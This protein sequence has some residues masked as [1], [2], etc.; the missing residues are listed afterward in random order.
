MA[1]K[2]I[3]ALK[4]YLSEPCCAV[5]F[6]DNLEVINK[7][8]TPKVNWIKGVPKDRWYADPF[9]LAVTNSTVELLVERY[10]YEDGKGV[11]SH[12]LI[13]RKNNHLIRESV[14]L[15][16]TTHLSF[17]FIIEENDVI[18]VMPE[19]YQSGKLSV[20]EYD[21]Y[22][23][24]LINQHILIN[25]PL[26]DAV[27]K[28]IDGYYYIFATK[29]DDNFYEAAKTLYV[30][31]STSLKGRYILIQTISHEKAEVRGAG[32]IIELG[33]NFIRPSQDCNDGY[34]RGV[35]F[36]KLNL[37][38]G[39][40]EIAEYDRLFPSDRRYSLGLHTYN[41]TSDIVVVDGIG[42]RRSWLSKI[43]S[44][45]YKNINKIR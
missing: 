31:R 43:A 16:L 39:I 4:L 23:N 20:Y 21:R 18:Y 13:N 15:E 41:R 9:I 2:I 10:K 35:I 3:N 32:E 22:H 36:S 7:I 42:Y 8:S 6:I 30:Y 24:Q 25:E 44:Y 11:L 33:G 29:Y 26:V 17:P 37:K 19:N 14:I 1:K 45:I 12:L 38:D 28:K 5:G 34:G 27:C 40:F